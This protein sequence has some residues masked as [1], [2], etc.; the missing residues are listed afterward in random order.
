MVGRPMRR[1]GRAGRAPAGARFVRMC[2]AAAEAAQKLS[3]G[4]PIWATRAGQIE[5]SGQIER[6]GRA[7]SRLGSPTSHRRHSEVR[8]NLG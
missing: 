1:R 4:S 5:R 7:R 3:A 8:H 2:S 6:R